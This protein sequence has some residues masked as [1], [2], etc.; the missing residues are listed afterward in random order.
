MQQK[1]ILINTIRGI[2]TFDKVVL[3]KE[4]P[5]II[6]DI[7]DTLLYNCH[8]E[9]E[10][11]NRTCGFLLD[12]F[13]NQSTKPRKIICRD[14][15][16]FVKLDER[17]NKRNGKIIFLSARGENRRKTV[18]S[19]FKQIGLDSTKY[20]I[21]CTTK[22]KGRYIYEVIKPQTAK[23]GELIFID[24]V[25]ENNLSVFEYFPESIQYLFCNDYTL[26]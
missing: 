16:G 15:H 4:N 22:T 26:I 2:K 13:T 8:P 17:V 25:Y 7:D 23:Y 11:E 19:D 10:P 6:C 9:Q 20:E 24:D 1:K 14:I 5:L 3:R 21:H 12:C 18:Y